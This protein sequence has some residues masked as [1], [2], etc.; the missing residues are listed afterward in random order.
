[1]NHPR[2]ITAL[3]AAAAALALALSACGTEAPKG[4]AGAGETGKEPVTLT[5]A[6]FNEFGYEDCSRNMSRSTP[7]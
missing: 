3:S 6:T 2:K 4:A 7:M 5:V 1:M